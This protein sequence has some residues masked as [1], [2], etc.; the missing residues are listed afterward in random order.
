MY[1]SSWDGKHPPRGLEDVGPFTKGWQ[2]ERYCHYPQELVLKLLSTARIRKIQLLSHHY[3]IASRVDLAVE[4][5]PD[6]NSSSLD[7]AAFTHLG[8]ISLADNKSTHFKSR[9]LKSVNVDA[10]G[11]LVRLVF[12]HNHI[13][14]LNLY[15]QVAL[16]AVNIITDS[17]PF[18]MLKPPLHAPLQ[19]VC[20][21]DP[22]TRGAINKPILSA[23]DDLAF[24]MSQDPEIGEIIRRLYSA[25][26][27]AVKDES[28]EY[29]KTLKQVIGEL[30]KIGEVLCR[31]EVEK[32]CAVDMEDYDSARKKKVKSDTLRREVYKQLS[33][34]CTQSQLSHTHSPHH[35]HL[36][37][38]P[39][40]A[41]I[42]EGSTHAPT[43][44]HSIPLLP[45]ILPHPS[46]PSPRAPLQPYDERILP[47]LMKKSD[48]HTSSE[49]SR[50]D[51]GVGSPEE[52]RP[53]TRKEL[54]KVSNAV[55]V[56]GMDQVKRFFAKQFSVRERGLREVQQSLSSV[57]SL[58]RGETNVWVRGTSEL[59]RRALRDN[60]FSCFTQSLDLLKYLLGTFCKIHKLSHQ[61]ISVVLDK[62]LPILLERTGDTSPR[63]LSVAMDAI[64]D[65]ARL[66]KVKSMAIVG[67]YFVKPL[68]VMFMYMKSTQDTHMQSCMHM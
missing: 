49:E 47:A 34:L 16:V 11:Q 24:S 20:L 50:P 3:M 64:I 14:N 58:P 59:V 10:V 60:V 32:R 12:H 61:E 66:E 65:I 26:S 39:V 9:E 45:P 4:R 54:A 21:S 6:N 25:K 35:V 46:H 38:L 63:I 18:D 48:Q 44:Q 19:G 42:A 51:R 36:T 53:L 40:D 8:H 29:A 55:E 56:F 30:E 31:Y 15:N 68:K 37:L 33:T 13:N 52:L 1:C 62:T 67:Q 17:T 28:Y 41:H 57:T 23:T 27:Q 5:L 7:H 43:T 2:S 22:V